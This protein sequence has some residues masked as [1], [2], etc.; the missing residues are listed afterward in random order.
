MASGK[1]FK[2]ALRINAK[3]QQAARQVTTFFSI[4]SIRYLVA[5]GKSDLLNFVFFVAFVVKNSIS[6]RAPRLRGNNFFYL[7]HKT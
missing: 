7:T 2:L 6:L 1:D 4:S 3:Y 5:F